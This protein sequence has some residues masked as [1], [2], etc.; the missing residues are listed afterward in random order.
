MGT[1]IDW[2][3]YDTLSRPDTN[4]AL[5]ALAIGHGIFNYTCDGL[6][7]ANPPTYVSQFTELYDAAA[8]AASLADEQ[9]FHDLIPKLHGFDLADL[10]NSTLSCMGSIGTL[11]STAVVML[12]DIST[13]RVSVSETIKSPS[14]SS[15]NGLWV[16]SVSPDQA[17]EVY[18]VEMAGGAVPAICADQPGGALTAEYVAEYWVYH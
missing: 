6:A 11:E 12:Y 14:N 2:T 10:D 18:R 17:W 7:P 5:T 16:H 8:L 13:F 4:K 9:Q 3:G 1:E 15:F